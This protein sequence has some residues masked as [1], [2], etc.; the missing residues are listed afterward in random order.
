[1]EMGLMSSSN[2]NFRNNKLFDVEQVETIS[3]RDRFIVPPFSVL[4]GKEAWWAARRRAWKSFGIKSELGRADNLLKLSPAALDAG[5]GNGTGIFDP[6]LCELAYRW[7]CP[8]GGTVLDPFAGGSVRGIV[9]GCLGYQ[10]HGVDIRSEQ[11]QENIKQA[12]DLKISPIPCWYTG[13]SRDFSKVVNSIQGDFIFSS[14]PY[15]YREHYSD[16]PNDLNNSKTYELF[17]EGYFRAIKQV[18]D[19]LTDNRFACFEVAEIRDRKGIMIDFIGDTIRAF[20][21]AGLHLYGR[22]I[23]Y[24]PLGSAAIRVK[25]FEYAR[26]FVPVHEDVL[27]FVKGDIKKALAYLFSS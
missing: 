11:I 20:S 22:S 25:M 6:V 8:P 7:F 1:M 24:K 4:D 10:Y 14:P 27:V 12:R 18:C 2:L 17:C 21:E 26:K 15:F 3:L 23:H 19:C 9:A 16:L 13:D 5:G